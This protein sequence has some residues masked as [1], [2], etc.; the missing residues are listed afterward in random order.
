MM[1]TIV[2]DVTVLFRKGLDMSPWTG[3]ESELVLI[4][5]AVGLC[6]WTGFAVVNAIANSR[7]EDRYIERLEALRDD[8]RQEWADHKFDGTVR[9]DT[10]F[11]PSCDICLR[12]DSEICQ[13]PRFRALV[14]Q[15][16]GDDAKDVW[17]LSPPLKLQAFLRDLT[18]TPGLILAKVIETGTG[19]DQQWSFWYV[20][21]GEATSPL[22][23]MNRLCAAADVA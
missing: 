11:N 5:A 10:E 2:R 4:A 1:R 7:K 12:L 16:F 21:S 8:L 22:V 18:E 20:T 9:Y 23:K 19:E 17:P 3:K 13:T 6:I 15:Y 14:Q